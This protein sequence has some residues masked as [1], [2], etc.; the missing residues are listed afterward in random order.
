MDDKFRYFPQPILP[1][2]TSRPTPRP[3]GSADAGAFDRILTEKLQ[4]S[5]EVHFS[6]HALSRMESRG[7]ELSSDEMQRLQSAIQ[8]VSAKGGRDS[9]VLL[10]DNALVVSVKNS[11]VVTVVDRE[12]LKGNVFT[13]IDSAVIA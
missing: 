7:I 8:A 11:T 13:N 6:R 2:G 1:P 5:R 9:L 4:P 3:T 10:D 12:N